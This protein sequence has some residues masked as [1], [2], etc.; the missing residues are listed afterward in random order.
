MLGVKIRS[1]QKG[2]FTKSST[3]K[4]PSSPKKIIVQK[5]FSLTQE[6][7]CTVRSSLQ[8]KVDG[9]LEVSLEGLEPLRSDRTI[10]DPVVT[11]QGHTHHRAHVKTDGMREEGKVREVH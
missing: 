8:E 1:Y 5:T 4:L 3:N 11:A 9:F 7:C 10:N 2:F 6:L